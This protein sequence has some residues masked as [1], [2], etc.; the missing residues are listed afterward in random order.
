MNIE[1]RIEE[2]KDYRLVEELTRDAFWNIY[3]PGCDTHLIIHKLRSTKE[4]VKE[5]DIVAVYENKIVG[6]IIYA[7]AKIKDSDKEY[8]IL[9]FG[10]ISVLP[11]YQNKGIGKK[12]IEYTKILAKE[13]G[14]KAI[15]IYGY[16]DYYK[17]FGFKESKHYGI[18]NKDK[19]YPAA[20]LVLEL[21]PNA[22]E[23]IKG[24]F[25]EGECY[26]IDENELIEFDKGFIEKELKV[27]KS[28]ERFLEMANKFL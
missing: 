8:T 24:V 4:F 11:E 22:L 6:N 15:L 3:T 14:Y 28:Q 25:D 26:I 1:L 2:E 9:T 16:P 27:T 7:E 19:K 17:R 20:L 21:Y 10:P 23:G 5:L 12:L 13:M 18:T